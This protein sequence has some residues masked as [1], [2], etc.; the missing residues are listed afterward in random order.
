M[1]KKFIKLT[2]MA[3]NDKGPIK[4]SFGKK[5]NALIDAA[6]TA[7]VASAARVKI[8]DIN[9][10]ASRDFTSADLNG[11][12]EV[13]APVGVPVTLNIPA[14]LGVVGDWIA[15]RKADATETLT[16]TA[17]ETLTGENTVTDQYDFI[18]VMKVADGIWRTD[19][20]A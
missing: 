10:T 5:E 4:I 2:T 7:S 20:T 16:V 17:A 18:Q 9:V 8:V 15:V 12:L 13:A 19:K 3:T 6:V 11:Y 14:A 1:I